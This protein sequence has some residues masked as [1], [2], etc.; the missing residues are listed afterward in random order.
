[1]F[2]RRPDF[3]ASARSAFAAACVTLLLARGGALPHAAGGY[4]TVAVFPIE[5]LSGEGVPEHEF[6]VTLIQRL[7][8]AGLRVIDDAALDAF[9]VRHRVRYAA[10]LETATA[11]ALVQELGVDG[12]V[13]ASIELSDS[14]ASPKLALMARLVSVRDVPTV[15]WADDV[16]LAGDEAPGLF[17]LGIVNDFEVL[18]TRA[19]DHVGASLDGWLKTGAPAR[20]M[21]NRP[22]FRPRSEFRSRTL[23]PGTPHS[24]AVL[25][26]FNLSDRRNAGEI[27]AWLFTRHLAAFPEFRVVDAG[28]T[29]QQL[30]N[31]RVI[32]DGG[33]ALADAENVASLVDTDLVLAG[34]V[35]SYRD[36]EGSAGQTR[37]EFS[38]VLFEKSTRR[39][40]FSSISDNTGA[41]GVGWFERGGS[42]TAHVM[43]TQMVRRT[44]EAIAGEGR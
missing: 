39:I 30:L 5:N 13:F 25:P 29:R 37:V 7:V 10:G 28:V 11:Q 42:K 12:V 1:V 43:A 9:M 44:V 23:T 4:S 6:R 35:L 21:R 19:L 40:V 41:D 15:V 36:F 24:V 26:F 2:G 38:T 31:A 32:M 27:L 18:Q 34:R 8:S 33:I 14:S 16:G 20:P 22:T 17:D 3:G